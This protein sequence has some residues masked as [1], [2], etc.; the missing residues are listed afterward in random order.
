MKMGIKVV[1]H[2]THND[3]KAGL[4]SFKQNGQETKRKSP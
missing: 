3:N 4:N 2:Q 1:F